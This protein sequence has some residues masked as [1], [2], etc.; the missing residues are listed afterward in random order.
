MLVGFFKSLL[1]VVLSWRNAKLIGGYIILE[2][3]EVKKLDQRKR[4]VA[5]IH[6]IRGS[7]IVTSFF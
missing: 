7:F 1:L 6:L 5:L 3:W 2:G 4:S